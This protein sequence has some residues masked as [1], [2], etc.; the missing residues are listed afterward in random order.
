MNYSL[1]QPGNPGDPQLTEHASYLTIDPPLK[2]MF[3]RLDGNTKDKPI[4]TV[5]LNLQADPKIMGRVRAWSG[6]NLPNTGMR[7]LGLTVAKYELEKFYATTAVEFFNENDVKELET[8]LKKALPN[9]ARVLSLFLGGIKIETEGGDSS[10]ANNP[11]SNP[12]GGLPP[13][14]GTGGALLPGIQVAEEG[15]A[16]KLKLS[17]KARYLIIE[18]ELN[19]VQRA[20][21]RIYGFTESTVAKMRGMV[22]MASPV[23]LWNELSAAAIKLRES[24]TVPRGT[25]QRSEGTGGRL[26]RNWPPHARVSWMAGLLP[27]LGHDDI[28]RSI[29]RDKSWREDRNLKAGSHLIPAFLDPRYP[30]RSWYAQPDSLGNRVLGSTHYVG[31]AGIGVDAGDYKADDPSVAKKLGVFGYDRTTKVSDVTDGLANTIYMME[32]PPKYQRPWIAGGGATVMGVPETKSVKPFV[33]THQGRRGVI[34]LMLD[35]SVRFIADNVSD[36]V[37]KS[38]CTIKGGETVDLEKVAPKVR[39]GPEMK[40]EDADKDKDDDKPA[41]DKPGEKP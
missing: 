28:Y 19:L 25:F 30:D 23:P 24:G 11:P 36:E 18:T 21:D 29:E 37:F 33:H 17:R 12:G 34:V 16:S 9:L 22:D 27:Y 3:D 2:A 31:V 20:F 10:A 26:A 7:V 38:L 1:L 15:P 14:P 40:T 4:L 41:E 35:G 8:V 13:Q 32:V 5:V 39:R 6:I